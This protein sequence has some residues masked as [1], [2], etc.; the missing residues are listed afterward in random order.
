MSRDAS[1]SESQRQIL[2]IL[3]S[4]A[5]TGL[6]GFIR[7]IVL[8]VKGGRLGHSSSSVS[9]TNLDCFCESV[10]TIFCNVMT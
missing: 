8:P 6:D 10:V 2:H 9:I 4:G 3:Q 1:L 5:K 7:G